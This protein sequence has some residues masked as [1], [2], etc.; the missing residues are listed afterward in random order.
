[1][2]IVFWA[3]TCQPQA[4]VCLLRPNP[5]AMRPFKPS[6]WESFWKEHWGSMWWKGY[7]LACWSRLH[8]TERGSIYGEE[9]RGGLRGVGEGQG[10]MG[11]VV[12]PSLSLTEQ[13]SWL[14]AR[15]EMVVRFCLPLSIAINMQPGGQA[16]MHSGSHTLVQVCMC[17]FLAVCFRL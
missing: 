15:Q 16:G 5:I 17:P 2:G 12:Y 8:R 3:P 6:A 7:C 13:V 9:V 4:L 11:A 1:M 10:H 14:E